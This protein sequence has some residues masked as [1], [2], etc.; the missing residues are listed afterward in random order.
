LVVVTVIVEVS[1][2]EKHREKRPSLSAMCAARSAL[3][4]AVC[5]GMVGGLMK[6][7][8]SALPR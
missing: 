6:E 1:L 4:W 7:E 2:K 3:L 8:P 5:A